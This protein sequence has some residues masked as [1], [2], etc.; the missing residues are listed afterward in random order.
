MTWHDWLPLGLWIGAILVQMVQPL[1]GGRLTR[2][3]AEIIRMKSKTSEEA[4]RQ[5]LF[6]NQVE[7][8]LVKMEER[9]Q[10]VLGSGSHR[11]SKEENR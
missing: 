2:I 4:G 9:C 1:I 11:V 3:E 8:R 6:V 7:V 5:Q 10:Y